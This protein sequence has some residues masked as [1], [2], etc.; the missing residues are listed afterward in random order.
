MN[1]LELKLARALAED[2]AQDLSD[3][4]MDILFGFGL[5]GF[6]PVTVSL[7]SIARCMR[8][9]CLCWDGSWDEHQYNEDLPHYR[10]NVT[11]ADFL[12]EDATKVLVAICQ[13]RLAA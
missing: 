13:Q 6:Q 3:A 4:D 9:Q 1:P 7:R 5:P 11:V 2:T 10:R 8:W 12:R